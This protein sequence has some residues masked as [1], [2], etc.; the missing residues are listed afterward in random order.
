MKDKR[1]L[2][3]KRFKM[4][5]AGKL[6][7]VA[8]LSIGFM[9]GTVV[10]N[11][12]IAHADTVSSNDCLTVNKNVSDNPDSNQS[13]KQDKVTQNSSFQSSE[14]SANMPSQGTSP[15]SDDSEIVND[16]SDTT[17][18]KMADESLTNA[19][20]TETGTQN[21]DGNTERGQ[22]TDASEP[23]KLSKTDEPDKNA[24]TDN[25]ETTIVPPH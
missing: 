8:G 7:I 15:I 20:D 22:I 21:N 17:K 12:N 9:G 1:Q 25:S 13:L 18:N 6:W 4:F 14:T 11:S 19:Q 23:D 3:S 5:K 16:T 24:A 10:L 2:L